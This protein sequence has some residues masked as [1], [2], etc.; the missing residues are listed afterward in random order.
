MRLVNKTKQ[1]SQCGCISFPD[2]K[3]CPKCGKSYTGIVI[4]QRHDTVL[5]RLEFK[6]NCSQ[7]E[8]IIIDLNTLITIT[9][10]KQAA[11]QIN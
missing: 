1:C 3:H 10:I 6:G 8:Y 4:P 2:S 7:D 9:K 11:Y 5:K